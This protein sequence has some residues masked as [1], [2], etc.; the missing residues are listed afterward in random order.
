[1]GLPVTVYR[2]DDAGAPQLTTNRKP[3][4][5]INILNKCLVDG[6]GTKAA[7]GWTKEFEDV[8]T[9][10]VVFRNSPT[11]GS[12]GFVRFASYT[13]A[14]TNAT[15]MQIRTGLSMTDIDTFVKETSYQRGIS[16]SAFVSV[17]WFL[18]GTSSSFYFMISASNNSKVA[19]INLNLER[20]CF[21]GD[22]KP[23]LP[24]DQC[25]F[26]AIAD[27]TNGTQ[28][29]QNINYDAAFYGNFYNP[30]PVSGN[31]SYSTFKLYGAD[32]SN[33][34]KNYQCNSSLL[35]TTDNSPNSMPPKMGIFCV[36]NIAMAGTAVNS[37]TADSDGIR[38]RNS[39]KTPLIRGELPG[40]KIEV[41]QRY[42][43]E[44][45]PVT[46]NIDGADHW[47]LRTGTYTTGL[48]INMEEW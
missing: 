25:T 30:T 12:G 6:Y 5:I 4:E 23:Y 8:V 33:D 26:M 21:V 13:G 28:T 16:V 11:T 37:S 32:G 36:A 31:W 35:I 34:V 18:I 42:T 1:M 15:V 40:M 7:L 41:M 22:F 3:S 44:N 24:A 39:V 10:K 46:E 20:G 48:W 19:G 43:S 38:V 14:D 17:Q 9:Q 29:G 27:N 47:L 45:W 2:W